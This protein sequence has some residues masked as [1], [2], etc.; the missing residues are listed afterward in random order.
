MLRAFPWWPSTAPFTVVVRTSSFPYAS[1]R[2][3]AREPCKTSSQRRIACARYQDNRQQQE[4]ADE[5]SER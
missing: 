1:S 2:Q 4:E 5:A 3:R